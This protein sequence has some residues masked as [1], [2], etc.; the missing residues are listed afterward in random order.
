M[1]SPIP[2]NHYGFEQNR[3]RK[4]VDY[5]WVPSYC[6]K[7]E[8]V[9][10]DCDKIKVVEKRATTKKWVPKV[11]VQPT[12]PANPQIVPRQSVTTGWFVPRRTISRHKSGSHVAAPIRLVICMVFCLWMNQLRSGRNSS[13][14]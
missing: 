12:A 10:H 5:D 2:E 8:Q 14:F 11:L 6:Q 1:A 4:R 13:T 9:G 3:I 7:F